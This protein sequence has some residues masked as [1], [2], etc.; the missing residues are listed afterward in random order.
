MK[1]KGS[2]DCAIKLY[3]EGGIRSSYRG[4]GATLLRGEGWGYP[5]A[6]LGGGATLLW[7]EGWG[8]GYP[9]VGV[10]EWGHLVARWGEGRGHAVMIF[11]PA[12]CSRYWGILWRV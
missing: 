7:G 1:Y 10:R 8:W 9:A 11:S 6:R 5:V 12:R 4:V 3:Q 2:L